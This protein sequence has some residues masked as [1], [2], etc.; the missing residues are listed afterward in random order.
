MEPIY[1]SIKRIIC[2]FI[3]IIIG[4]CA[5]IPKKIVWQ[6]AQEVQ[7]HSYKLRTGDIIIK[8]KVWN[9]PISWGGH[10]GVMINDYYVGDYPKIGVNFYPLPPEVWLNEKRKVVVLRYKDF[11]DKFR[12][13][14]M[15]NAW[16]Y[17]HSKYLITLNKKNPK[18][19]YCSKYV[20]FL[21][22]KTA[23]DLGY[24]LDIDSNKGLL[25]FPYDFLDSKYLEQVI[26]K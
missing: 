15:E 11:T 6:D 14:F 10:C 9:E 23:K 4:G 17:S 19:F 1:I 2:I 20:W 5:T 18:D 13:K 16:K 3:L 21:F 12:K 24:N 26:I 25:V 8:N 22:Y 7:A